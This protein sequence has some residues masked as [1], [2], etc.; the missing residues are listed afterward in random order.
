[1]RSCASVLSDGVTENLGV[2]KRPIAPVVFYRFDLLWSDG[3]DVTGT[4]VLQRRDRL[5]QVI[6]PVPGIQ[7][8]GYLENCGIVLYRLTKEKGI[9]GI[10]AKRKTSTYRPG[11]RSPDWLKIK[12]RQQQEF[13]VCGFT[14]GKGS[15]K[16]FGALLLGAYR[17][18]RLRYSSLRYWVYRKGIEGS[19][20]STEAVFYEPTLQSSYS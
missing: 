17:N 16:H 4:T 1:M 11:K 2:L 8:G 7:V 3:R 6:K 10:I 9:E 18:G 19:N 5:E 14:E 13:V 15:R 20:R 12:A